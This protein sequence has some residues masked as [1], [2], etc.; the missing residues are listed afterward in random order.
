MT[1]QAILSMLFD[2][3]ARITVLLVG[4]VCGVAVAGYVTS[5]AYL[6]LRAGYERGILAAVASC[7][8]ASLQ[9]KRVS[10]SAGTALTPVREPR[11]D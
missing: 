11:P 1:P 8:E 3:A 9:K 5:A 7:V 6:A 2:Y 10:A 4:A